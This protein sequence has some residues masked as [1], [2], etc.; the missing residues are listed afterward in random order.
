M[1]RR[2]TPV[3]QRPLRTERGSAE[4]VSTADQLLHVIHTFRQS[5]LLDNVYSIYDS[6]HPWP[7]AL[8]ICQCKHIAAILKAWCICLDSCSVN[9]LMESS[10][11]YFHLQV[12]CLCQKAIERTQVGNVIGQGAVKLMHNLM[13]NAQSQ[14]KQQ[15]ISALFYE[16]TTFQLVKQ[17]HSDMELLPDNRFLNFQNPSTMTTLSADV[18]VKSYLIKHKPV[19]NREQTKDKSSVRTGLKSFK[20]WTT[21]NDIQLWPTIQ[22]YL[23]GKNSPW[24]MM[25]HNAD[26]KHVHFIYHTRDTMDA[27]K[28]GIRRYLRKHTQID[29]IYAK[30]Q[31]D[32]TYI[33]TPRWKITSELQTPDWSNLTR[34]ILHKDQKEKARYQ[35]EAMNEGPFKLN[36]LGGG[37]TT[38][39]PRSDCAFVAFLTLFTLFCFAALFRLRVSSNFLPIKCALN[40]LLVSLNRYG[41]QLTPSNGGHY[42]YCSHNDYLFITKHRTDHSNERQIILLK[43]TDFTR[44][45]SYLFKKIIKIQSIY[46]SGVVSSRSPFSR[47]DIRAL[48]S[49]PHDGIK[50]YAVDTTNNACSGIKE[51]VFTNTTI[52]V[53]QGDSVSSRLCTLC[54]KRRQAAPASHME[55]FQRFCSTD[56]FSRSQLARH[57]IKFQMLFGGENDRRKSK[58][59]ERRRDTENR[60]M[61]DKRVIVKNE[62]DLNISQFIPHKFQA[63]ASFPSRILY[64]FQNLKEIRE[65]KSSGSSSLDISDKNKSFTDDSRTTTSASRNS[66]GL[67]DVTS[68]VSDKTPSKVRT[69]ECVSDKFSNHSQI[70]PKNHS[71]SRSATSVPTFSRNSDVCFPSSGVASDINSSP[72]L[73]QTTRSVS[74]SRNNSYHRNTPSVISGT[75]E[76]Y[77]N[78]SPLDQTWDEKESHKGR[79]PDVKI[80]RLNYIQIELNWIELLISQIPVRDRYPHGSHII[81]KSQGNESQFVGRRS[82]LFC[83]ARWNSK[84]S[85]QFDCQSDIRNASQVPNI[86]GE[87]TLVFGQLAMTSPDA[88]YYFEEDEEIL[89]IVRLTN[90][91]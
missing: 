56:Y 2:S 79:E 82:K 1:L 27:T 83:T 26:H 91:A 21:L 10:F 60:K 23:Y 12:F 43:W 18:A 44:L 36:E 78:E 80:A 41:I 19:T 52:G 3:E 40:H 5:Q 8:L 71:L 39:S 67:W 14:V 33:S 84:I 54:L 15:S 75:C 72:K 16:K 17:S 24:A 55:K 42:S 4:Q 46:L 6:I 30:T 87:A 81:M 37:G 22:N 76:N 45:S 86:R 11:N 50:I 38:L 85:I 62:K 7:Q 89:D 29:A 28:N 88:K 90:S 66:L 48:D 32:R 74:P 53:R 20:L 69:K 49:A 51:N 73:T 9:I 77:S 64:S 63:A 31:E 61:K 70:V 65:E 25:Q 59:F 34:H 68:A 58:Y 47:P 35:I 13:H 57:V